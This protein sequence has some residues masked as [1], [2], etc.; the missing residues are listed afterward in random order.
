M[1][2]LP[3]WK[4]TKGWRYRFQYRGRKY[5]RA[6][7]KTKAEARAA[8]EAKKAELKKAEKEQTRTGITFLEAAN[9][10]LDWS[11]R[12][13]AD[14]TYKYKAYVFS[15][16]LA[17]ARDQELSS[18]SI[19]VLELYLR[20]RRSNHNYNVHRKELCAL[21]AWAWRRRYITENPCFWLEKLPEQRTV[22]QIPTPEE[23]AKILLAAGEDRPL[24]LVLYHTLAR[25]D[26]V[27]RLRWEDVNF[28]ERT[29]RLWTRKRKDG[30]WAADNL[31]MNKILYDTLKSLWTHRK[32]ED[33]VFL[34][35]KTNS[36]YMHRPKLMRGICKR[37]GVR[38]FGFH[39]I[40]HYV[41]SLLHDREKVSLAQVSKLLRHQTKATT[42][43]Y[44]QVVD[45]GSRDALAA[46]ESAHL[47]MT[48]SHAQE[49]ISLKGGGDE[50]T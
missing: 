34:N 19:S 41:A 35:P 21:L 12:R 20:T 29:V 50:G 25:V 24:L 7:F 5:N 46:L 47:P 33:I 27:L 48:P 18:I 26:E 22:K 2:F 37:A 11:K 39:A 31:P 1:I 6:W 49:Q 23:M 28:S 15:Q 38:H 8:E 40:R 43:R 14:K 3:V 42:E 30:S 17:Y 45:Q 9:E 10:Y 16:F 4:E 44:L 36:R 32:S 13:H